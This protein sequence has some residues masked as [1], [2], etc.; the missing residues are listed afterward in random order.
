MKENRYF[1]MVYLL[2][3]KGSMTAPG[4]WQIILKCR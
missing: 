1:Q 2:L 3:E 4:I